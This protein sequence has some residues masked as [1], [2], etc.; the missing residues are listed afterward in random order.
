M[1]SFNKQLDVK[2]IWERTTDKKI[3]K[4]TIQRRVEGLLRQHQYSLEER[5]DRFVDYTHSYFV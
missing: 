1:I 3:Q 4:N 5:R 2:H